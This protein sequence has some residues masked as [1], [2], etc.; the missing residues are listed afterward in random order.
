MEAGKSAPPV[1]TFR[2]IGVL[3]STYEAKSGVP[4]QG[5]F[6]SESR[7]RAEIFEEYGPGLQDVEGFS[8]LILLYVFHKSKGYDLVCQPYMEDELHGVF[9][10]RAP[11]RPNPIGFSVVRLDR[12]DGLILHLS[13][14]DFLDGTPL[15]DIKPFVPRFDHRSRVRV[16]WMSDTFRDGTHRTVSDDRF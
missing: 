10:V 4:I 15:L 12:R 2:P 14:V 9:S 6:D 16:G 3:R 11:R 1:F 5:V 13:E 8:H 7:G